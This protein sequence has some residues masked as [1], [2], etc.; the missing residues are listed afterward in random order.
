MHPST[1]HPLTLA[2]CRLGARMAAVAYPGFT[3]FALAFGAAA[4]QRGLSFGQTL[5]L[6]GFVYAGAAQMVAL[7]IWQQVWSPATI[8]A[9][10]T[11][12]AVVNARLILLGT[13]L[14]PWFAGEPKSLSALNLFLMTDANWLFTT[15]YYN[16]GGRDLGV[17]LGAGAA[18][19]LLWIVMTSIGFFGGTLVPE[20]RRFGLDFVMPIFFATMLVPLWKG[21]RPALPW[22][23]A[24]GVALVV[25]ALTPGYSFIVAGALTGVAT[26]MLLDE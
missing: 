16:E 19:W 12:T 17:Y 8:L 26:G 25:H 9:V 24:G 10:M 4:S 14:Q 21:P 22:L 13:T 11:V 23:A 3:L 15:R 2:G 18:L 6:S 1:R 7:E 20:P 5:G